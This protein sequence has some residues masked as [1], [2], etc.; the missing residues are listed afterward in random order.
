M[1]AQII[2]LQRLPKSLSVFDYAVPNTLADE[3]AV[4]QI[5]EILFRKAKHHGLV[6]ALTSNKEK[7]A[8]KL[9]M[10]QNILN[11]IPLL[12][13]QQINLLLEL[14]VWYGVSPSTLIKM[15]LPPLQKSKIKKLEL[16]KIKF[17]STAKQTKIIFEQYQNESEHKTQLTKHIKHKTLI[18]VPEVNLIDEVKQLLPAETQEKIVV[19]HSELSE[20]QQFENWMQIRNQKKI[21]IIGTRSAVFLPLDGFKSVIIDYEHDENHK[22]WDQ[23]PRFHVK[24]VIEKLNI[25]TTLLTYSP[26][27]V[28]YYHVHKKK[29]QGNLKLTPAKDACLTGRQ[30]QIVEMRDE[31]LGGNYGALSEAVKQAI[32]NAKQDIFIYVNRLGFATSVGCNDCGYVEECPNCKNALVYHE[33]TLT[34][35]CHYCR[36]QKPMILVCPRC[37]SSLTKLYGAGTE[38]IEKEVRRILGADSNKEIIRLDSEN[39]PPKEN[40]EKSRVIIGTKMALRRIRWDKTDL[41]VLIDID[42]QMN[43]PEYLAQEEVWHLIQEILFRKQNGAKLIIQTFQKTNLI[44][45]SLSEPDRFYRTTLNSRRALGYPPYLYLTRYFY[46]NINAPAAQKEAQRVAADIRQELTKSE[47][48]IILLGPIEMHPKF[49]RGQFWY[50]IIAKL[51]ASNWQDELKFLNKFIPE[52]WKADPNPISIL[53]P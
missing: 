12:S 4:G 1:I 11:P 43:I 31:R 50:E 37:H 35:H 18:L 32:A 29:Y 13:I 47:K 15:A 38:F 51:S 39:F 34:L 46:G 8:V 42:R 48:K 7:K 26:S 49:Y 36:T 5:V 27:A 2:P 10:I 21:I 40:T 6:Y 41:A 33:K 53:S 14:S 22:H 17:K 9:E 23:A 20:K 24:D 3:I 44:C 19:W 30:A 45:R 52:N 28:T 25:K 16:R